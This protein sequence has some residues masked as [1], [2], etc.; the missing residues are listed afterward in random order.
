MYIKRL[1]ISGFG[2]FNK[3][4]ELGLNPGFN[5]FIGNNESGKSTLMTALRA[6]LFGLEAKARRNWEPWDDYSLFGSEILIE[7]D[8]QDFLF[9]R[10]FSTN[11]TS[12]ILLSGKDEEILFDDKI[13]PQS[14]TE[15]VQH[16]T[17]VLDQ[18]LG[19]SSESVFK[20]VTYID[21]RQVQTSISP[22]VRELISGATE[23]DYIKIYEG[24]ED[25]Y[26][27][28]TQINPDGKNKSKPRPL[29]LARDES[30]ALKEKL[31]VARE[32]YKQSAVL[33]IEI[34]NLEA[35]LAKLEAEFETQSKGN[36]DISEFSQLKKEEKE[37]TEQFDR[38]ESEMDKIK[39]NQAK[40]DI[41]REKKSSLSQNY[42]QFVIHDYEKIRE[43]AELLEQSR[44]LEQQKA[45]M[46]KRLEGIKSPSYPWSIG[47]IQG[48]IMVQ[49]L[50]LGLVFKVL[51]LALPIGFFI[52][53]ALFL[54]YYYHVRSK[55]QAE[56]RKLEGKAA[57]LGEQL[58][59]VRLKLS[60]FDP[61]MVK[62]LEKLSPPGMLRTLND[63]KEMESLKAEEGT[64]KT[65]LD[66]LTN[67]GELQK[68]R[69]QILLNKETNKRRLMELSK[70][71]PSLLNFD[72]NSALQY[73]LKIRSELSQLAGR[74]SQVKS[75]RDEQLLKLRAL[76]LES[77]E[78][79]DSL[80]D[81][82]EQNEDRIQFL[83]R[84][85]E[86]LYLAMEVLAQ[87]IQEFH[88]HSMGPLESNIS[89]VFNRI[90]HDRYQGVTIEEDY[91][92]CLRLPGLPCIPVGQVSSGAQDQLYFAVRLG[93]AA[94]LSG[95]GKLPF[96]LDDPFVN[97]DR[98][99]LTLVKD[100]LIELSH[101]YQV[102]L[103]VHDRVWLDWFEPVVEL[104]V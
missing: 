28:I 11:Q 14:H 88:E 96:I 38:V 77:G 8:Q 70:K 75:E 82:L 104:K 60:R 83:T 4:L 45:E 6:T 48:L 21:Q 86:A 74:I 95:S 59:D 89:R 61:A 17:R 81:Q 68:R 12:V 91:Q 51:F 25:D 97:Y 35:T 1:K 62:E 94:L 47:I 3:G 15:S 10:D 16:Y 46:V 85:K 9:R 87:C 92:P 22:Q 102:L 31:A 65:L 5:L 49:S 7:K 98:N 52:C 66:N 2:K 18:I 93:I 53:L 30:A 79:V 32:H 63:L 100:L 55:A 57:L 54:Y 73:G 19:I 101:D 41:I 99:R 84:R 71:Y 64:I 42:P 78:S 44:G 58:A 24:L 43:T 50:L 56:T 20:S 33:E 27:K 13:T 103:F 80:E 36:E 76:Q 72:L 90:T 39:T 69:N 29:E 67:P 37:L 40:I 23:S 34:N 26:Y